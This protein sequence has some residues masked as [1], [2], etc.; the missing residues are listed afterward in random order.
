MG[1]RVP[2]KTL[3]DHLEGG[4][5]LDGFLDQFPTVHREQAVALLE[6]YRDLLLAEAK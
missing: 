1:T 6:L 4:Y 3:F 2:V 5:T